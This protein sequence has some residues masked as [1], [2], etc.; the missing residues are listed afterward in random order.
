MLRRVKVSD[1]LLKRMEM[2]QPSTSPSIAGS[3]ALH[4]SLSQFLCAALQESGSRRDGRRLSRYG[5]TAQVPED[6][7]LPAAGTANS[8]ESWQKRAGPAISLFFAVHR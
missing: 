2:G 8:T 7:T 4:R 1:V 3:G 5:P 6:R